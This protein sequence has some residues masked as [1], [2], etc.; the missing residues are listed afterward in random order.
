MKQRLIFIIAVLLVANMAYSQNKPV[1]DNVL[2]EQQVDSVIK[3]PKFGQNCQHFIHYTLGLGFVIPGESAETQINA[4][5]HAYNLGFRYKLKVLSFYA[6]GADLSFNFTYNSIIQDSSR[7]LPN[8]NKIGNK[9]EL[10][11]ASE[12]ELGIYNRFNFGRRGNIIGKY[13]DLGTSYAYIYN[14]T[15]K[16]K[17]E[18]LQGERVLTKYSRMQYNE[19]LVGYYYA[20]IG[21]NRFSIFGKYR[22]TNFFK[23]KYSF[24]EMPRLMVGVSVGVY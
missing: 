21:I 2:M 24:S 23:S 1:L 13:I 10:F 4:G 9:K 16:T 14:V 15:Q 22:Y 12:A 3:K 5:S 20:R 8:V 7:Q 17:T 6:I 19:L 18:N 11:I